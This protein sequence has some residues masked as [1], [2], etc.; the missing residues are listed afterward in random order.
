MPT[1]AAWEAR[2]R[3][4]SEANRLCLSRTAIRRA[5]KHF[6]RRQSQVLDLDGDLRIL[7]IIP[8]ETPAKAF[9]EISDNDKAAARRL[10]LVTA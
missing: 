1:L 6:A 5:A 9:R 7:G 4:H 8:D 10:G 3:E 2:I